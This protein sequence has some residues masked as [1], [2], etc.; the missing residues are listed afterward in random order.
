MILGTAFLIFL[1]LILKYV[2]AWITYYNK[3]DSRL[4]DSTWRFTYDYPVIGERDISD[5]D[6]KDF[7]RLRR[8]KNKII[9][10]MYSIVL[11]M[12]I[13]SMSVLSQFFLF[14]FN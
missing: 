4:G 5:L 14:F 10:F 12:F 1:Y 11:I 6:D 2:L 9:L 8:K 13:A 7:V 3:L